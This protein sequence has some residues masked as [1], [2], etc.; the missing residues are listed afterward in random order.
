ML[1][2][3]LVVIISIAFVFGLEG[4]ADLTDNN[5]DELV[6]NEGSLWIVAFTAEWV[7]SIVI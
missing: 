7:W 3:L 4:I 1:K 5:F 6:T 2:K